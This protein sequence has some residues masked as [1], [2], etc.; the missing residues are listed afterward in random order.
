MGQGSASRRRWGHIRSAPEADNRDLTRRGKSTLFDHLIGAGAAFAHSMRR[1]A[2]QR[3]ERLGSVRLVAQSR[4]LA[5]IGANW[6]RQPMVI[7]NDDVKT[8]LS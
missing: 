1:A 8:I 2:R 4:I 3:A 7:E 5:C 6:T